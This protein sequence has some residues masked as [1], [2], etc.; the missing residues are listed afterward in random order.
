MKRYPAYK[1]SGVDWIGE[2]PKHWSATKLKHITDIKGRIGFKGYT[3]E[4]LV[5]DGEGALTIGAKHIDKNN[6]INLSEPEYIK[7]EKYLESPEIMVKTGDILVTQ[8]G[9]LGK[10]A[11]IENEIGNA[12]I[13]PSIVILKNIDLNAKYL[14]YFLNGDY[15]KRNTE[16]ISSSTAVPMISQEE[17]GNFNILSPL[18]TEQSQIAIFLDHKT[19]Q[20]DDL[21]DK[22]QKIIEL[23][24][25]DRTALINNAVTK[26][27]EHHVPMKDSGI[28]WIG[29]IPK[30]W[31]LARLGHHSEMIVPMRDKPTDLTGDIP[32]LRIEDFD[33]KYVS[34]SKTNQGVSLELIQQMNLKIFPKG[35]VLCSCSCNMGKTAIVKSPLITNQTFIGIVPKENI[36]SDFLFYLMQS[37][38]QYLNVI[39]TGAIQSYLSR[40]DFEKLLIPFPTKEEQIAI[41][42][43]IDQ[44]TLQIEELI[45]RK[46]KLIDQLKEYK[47]SLINEAVTGKIDVRNYTLPV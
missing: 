1:D 28:E 15:F 25:E 23:L 47:S 21:I 38:E 39:A 22:K 46:Q 13:N 29:D 40:N 2:I 37:S 30:H 10:V 17:L 5:K 14:Y 34:K 6:K 44:K 24:K 45:E 4:D 32:W 41:A 19:T 18:N 3:K 43:F 20:I 9:S 16:I 42:L 35:T 8:R 7:W 36:S 33:S 27:L 26:G 12:T 11:V 31:K